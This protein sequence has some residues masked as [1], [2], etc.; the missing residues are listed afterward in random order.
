M[1]I[2]PRRAG[3]AGRVGQDG[4]VSEEQTGDRQTGV[5]Q[6]TARFLT[7][8]V[9]LPRYTSTVIAAWVAAAW[10]SLV[11]DRF[12]HLYISSPEMRCGKTLLLEALN[13]I[14]PAPMF[15]SSI[16]TPALYRSIEAGLASSSGSI[17]KVK[18]KRRPPTL[19]L[20][21]AQFLKRAGS[22]SGE[23]FKELLKAGIEKDSK[24]YRCGS[25]SKDFK[26]E[27]F[28]TYCPKV[29][30]MIGEPDRVLADRSLL[31]E[32]RR[33]TKE[34]TVEHFRSREVQPRA[35]ALRKNLEQWAAD[36][37]QTAMKIYPCIE[38]LDIENNR[39]AD[40]LLPL[41]T[42]L[43]LD[44]DE[45]RD[46]LLA[47]AASLEERVKRQDSQSAGVRLLTACKEIFE[48]EGYSGFVPTVT[49]IDHLVSRPEDV[50]S[51]LTPE[52]LRNLLNPYGIRPTQNR[53][54]TQRG[55]YVADF[56]DAFKRYL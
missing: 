52:A 23:S 13:R 33:K 31:V 53:K 20:D 42:V 40:L 30:A 24:V 26:P 17:P 44:G 47:Y 34:D 49:L 55:Y 11:W 5:I 1:P 28:R 56:Q 46:T 6:E 51:R 43:L 8:Y 3:Q 9:V 36:N 54:R 35:D 15:A 50:W 22:E 45:R 32:M 38:Y 19:L 2:A 10:L 4:R 21:E 18:A 48:E 37:E 27:G 39:M 16:S 12:P 14:V 7:D 41:Q 25:K 29:V